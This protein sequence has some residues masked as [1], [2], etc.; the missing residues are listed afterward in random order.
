MTSEKRQKTDEK[1]TDELLVRHLSNSQL[2]DKAILTLS[3]ASLGFSVLL[4]KDVF[5][6][7]EA[8]H[9]TH[10]RLSWISFALAIIFILVSFL[11]SQLAIHTKFAQMQKRK[12]HRADNENHDREKTKNIPNMITIGLSIASVIVYIVAIALMFSF[13]NSNLNAIK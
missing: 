12:H 9:L 11:T 2:L 8:T 13:I 6:L 4:L 7:E 5:K 3:S 10:L 1:L